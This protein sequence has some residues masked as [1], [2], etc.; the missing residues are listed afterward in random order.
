[1]VAWWTFRTVHLICICIHVKT[2]DK[3]PGLTEFLKLICGPL[4]ITASEHSARPLAY[5][6]AVYR[7]RLTLKIRFGLTCLLVEDYADK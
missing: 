7:I 4:A 6:R 3:S 5:E 1:M 2:R